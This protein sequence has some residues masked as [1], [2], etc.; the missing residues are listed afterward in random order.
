[1]DKHPRHGAAP[2]LDDIQQLLR[3]SSVELAVELQVQTGL[4]TVD[5]DLEVVS[6]VRS[7]QVVFPRTKKLPL[8][9]LFPGEVCLGH[10]LGEI[11]MAGAWKCSNVEQ[12]FDYAFELFQP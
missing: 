5:E 1:M 2:E 8:L 12:I 10:R 6:H 11:T 7:P 9:G 3:R 4:V